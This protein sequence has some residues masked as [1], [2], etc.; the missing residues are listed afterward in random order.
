MK[1]KLLIILGVTVLVMGCSGN[2]ADYQAS[3]VHDDDLILAD[4]DGQP[5]S[6]PMLE[7]LMAER[8]VEEDDH[9]GMRDLF[10]ELVRVQVVAN[11]ARRE[12]IAD[13]P[14]V[15]ARRAVRD[16]EILQQEYFDRVYRESPPTED[17]LREVYEAQTA[18]SGDRQ[19]LIESILYGDQSEAL[20]AIARVEDGERE[21]DE[22]L[23]SAR[24]TGLTVDDD[25]WVD[26]GQ[27]PDSLSPLVAEADA[28]E[29]IGQPLQTANGWRVLRVVDSRPL[30]APAFEEVREGIARHLV[31][32]RIEERITELAEDAEVTPHLPLDEAADAE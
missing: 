14:R 24:A 6:L 26:L 21:F 29:M 3:H 30:D 19:F 5:I 20:R 28:G 18:R 10:D 32:Q 9:D 27:L 8:G 1:Y 15:R 31:R 16:L 25:L 2:D 12:G 23:A 4:V 7:Y 17:E 22:L 13:E 11:A